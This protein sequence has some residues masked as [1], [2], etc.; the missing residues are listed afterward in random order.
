MSNNISVKGS[1][2][3][4]STLAFLEDL[5]ASIKEKTVCIQRG[6]EFITLK[7]TDT[8]EMEIEAKQKKGKE[9][10]SI[11]LSWR[12]ELPKVESEEAE[13][14][15]SVSSK[16][17]EIP[18]VPAEDEPAPCDVPKG[19]PSPAGCEAKAP[20]AKEEFKAPES[21]PEADDKTK[22]AASKTTGAKK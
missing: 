1:M 3:F 9:K 2:D 22:A 18:A 21:K 14:P 12:Q 15:F 8:I 11:E 6:E 7:P 19:L 10:L 17:P 20:T 4:N 13:Q 5:V 16:E